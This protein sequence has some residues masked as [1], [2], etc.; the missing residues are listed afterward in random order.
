MTLWENLFARL[1]Y[2]TF[3]IDDELLALDVINTQQDDASFDTVNLE[4]HF[5]F[6][7][8]RKSE[9]IDPPPPRRRR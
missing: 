6:G 9:P 4:F 7:E 5:R 3:R 2:Q 8:P 1:E